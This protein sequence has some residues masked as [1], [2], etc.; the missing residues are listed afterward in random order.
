[1]DEM[2]NVQH[3]YHPKLLFATVLPSV[4]SSFQLIILVLRT[5]ILYCLDLAAHINHV[6]RC[7]RQPFFFFL[8]I[9]PLH[10]TRPPLNGR[11]T[12]QQHL[13]ARYFPQEMAETF[14]FLFFSVLFTIRNNAKPDGCH[15]FFSCEC[16][17]CP[18]PLQRLQLP[19][20]EGASPLFL[21]H[22]YTLKTGF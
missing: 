1:M 17:W 8:Q 11:R 18:N 12:N 3:N 20:W 5:A 7:S 6:F 15:M 4:L 19:H 21:F 13:A 2:T 16:A 14:F 22:Y 10:A 9:K